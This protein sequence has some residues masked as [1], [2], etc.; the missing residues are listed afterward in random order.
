LF[1]CSFHWYL[2]HCWSSLFILSFHARYL[3]NW[4]FDILFLFSETIMSSKTKYICIM[5]FWLEN[6]NY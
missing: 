4:T 6:D 5:I 2:W 1:L 3:L